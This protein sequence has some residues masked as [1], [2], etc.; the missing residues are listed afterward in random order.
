M[1]EVRTNHIETQA[2]ASMQKT[3]WLSKYLWTP[4]HPLTSNL[5]HFFYN[6]FILPTWI[7][8]YSDPHGRGKNLSFPK[9]ICLSYTLKEICEA[10]VIFVGNKLESFRE[11]SV[12]YTAHTVCFLN[13][14]CLKQKNLWN[15]SDKSLKNPYIFPYNCVLKV[16]YLT[17]LIKFG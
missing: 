13:R 9:R 10:L 17:F 12:V 6:V 11:A 8:I 4:H 5:T 7:F 16:Y 3:F 2:Q 14:V 15:V 1:N